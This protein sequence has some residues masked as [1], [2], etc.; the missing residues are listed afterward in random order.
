MSNPH[1]EPRERN[2]RGEN[3]I[4]YAQNLLVKNLIEKITEDDDLIIVDQRFLWFLIL[5]ALLT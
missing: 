1:K 4:E 2:A 5:F 3:P